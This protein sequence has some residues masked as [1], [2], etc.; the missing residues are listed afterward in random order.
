[1]NTNIL[2]SKI[3]RNN[4]EKYAGTYFR[5]DTSQIINSLNAEGKCALFGIQREDGIYTIIGEKYVYYSTVLDTIGEIPLNEFSE[6][7]HINAL[8]KG[9]EGSFEFIP[10]NDKERSVW[11]YNK[12]TMNAI[13]NIILWI[14]Q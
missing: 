12:S 8:K 14:N 11:L 4:L 9:K 5:D 1:M 7:L 2:K 6:I 3:K 10:I 13:W